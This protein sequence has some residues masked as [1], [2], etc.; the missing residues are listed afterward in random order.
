MRDGVLDESA[1]EDCAVAVDPQ[2][3][4]SHAKVNDQRNRREACDSG[5]VF[6]GS[7]GWDTK[8]AG[9]GPI[10]CLQLSGIHIDFPSLFLRFYRDRSLLY[11][12]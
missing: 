12:G 9:S 2:S 11:A 4:G 10:F 3:V 7:K 5:M 1:G 6:L 8:P